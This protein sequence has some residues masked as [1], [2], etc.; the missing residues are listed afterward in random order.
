MPNIKVL[1]DPGFLYDLNYLFFAKFNTQHYVNSFVDETKKEA[2]KKY[3]ID[4][5]QHFGDISDDLYVFYHAM[6]NGR[7]FMTTYY[8]NPY[9][10]HFST[11]FNFKFFKNLLSDTEGLIRNLMQF[12]LYDLSR[13]SLE[14]CF[15]STEKL[16]SYIKAS[17]YSSEEKNKLYEFFIDPTPYLQALQYE[18]IEKEILLSAYYKEHYATIL[19][20][21]NNTTFEVL[22]ENVKDIRDLSFLR[23]EEQSLYTSFCLVNKYFMQLFFIKEA[24]VYLLGYDYVSVVSAILKAKK[25]HSLEDLCSALSETS[26][27]RILELLLER[28]EVTCKDLEKIFNFSGSTAYHHITLLT[29]IGAVKIRNEGKTIFYSLNRNYFD[30]MRAQLKVFSND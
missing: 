26:R 25:T 15:S 16:F 14:E 17:K 24:A 12:Y 21:H 29:K 8:I 1:K 2:Y 3:L 20:A 23:D 4:T 13:E 5:L 28:K 27:I 10:D 22:C 30:M 6:K 7:C 19:E 18:L 11:D 9:K